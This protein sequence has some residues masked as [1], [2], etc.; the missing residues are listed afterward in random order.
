MVMRMLPPSGGLGRHQEVR[1]RGSVQRAKIVRT[2]QVL[3]CMCT[4]T[5]RACVVPHG[6]AKGAT[7]WEQFD[8]TKR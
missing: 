2:N 7:Q 1:A 8:G 5:I 3:M 4:N 6:A